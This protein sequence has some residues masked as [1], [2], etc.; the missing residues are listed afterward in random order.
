MRKTMLLAP[1][2]LLVL[3][4]C[5]TPLNDRKSDEGYVWQPED[6]IS[7]LDICVDFTDENI[8]SWNFPQEWTYKNELKTKGYLTFT[9]EKET[10]PHIWFKDAIIRM[11]QVRAE[12]EWDQKHLVSFYVEVCKAGKGAYAY[13]IVER[14]RMK[15]HSGTIAD[16]I[17]LKHDSIIC[18]ALAILQHDGYFHYYALFGDRVAPEHKSHSALGTFHRAVYRYDFSLMRDI[19][20]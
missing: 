3:G 11:G 5:I 15:T 20:F 14:R 2:A 10:I 18:G 12:S 7:D 16:I 8:L 17:Y 1:L 13:T 4:G 9:P 6:F 19:I